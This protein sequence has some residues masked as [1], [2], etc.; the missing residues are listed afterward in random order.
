M[1]S[2]EENE[3]TIKTFRKHWFVMFLEVFLF[4]GVA[5]APIA[6]L[7]VTW[8]SLGVEMIPPMGKIF[9]VLIITW[10]LFL[11]IG[12][13]IVYT[14]YYLDVWMLTNRRLVDIDQKNL[15]RREVSTVRIEN[16]EDVTVEV[17]GLFPSLLGYGN[18]HVQSAAANKEFTIHNVANPNHVKELILREQHRE[19]ERPRKVEVI[20]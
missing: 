18:L 6:A 15:F 3:K 7:A 19:Y 16:I 8:M 5:A 17:A 13:F 20:T 11:W 1:F 2:L 10:L 4:V 14:N 9:T 12:F